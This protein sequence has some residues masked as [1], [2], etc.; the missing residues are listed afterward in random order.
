MATMAPDTITFVI[1]AYALTW[2]C[3]A[4]Y[5][6]HAHAALRKARAEYDRASRQPAGG[7]R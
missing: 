7:A 6:L 4:A 5:A 3:L 2:V 1:A